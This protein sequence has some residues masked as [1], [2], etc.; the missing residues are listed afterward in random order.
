MLRG[1][2]LRVR[3]VRSPVSI[4]N[5][6]KFRAWDDRSA[7]MR[8]GAGNRQGLWSGGHGCCGWAQYNAAIYRARSRL[9][10]RALQTLAAARHKR[11]QRRLNICAIARSSHS[12]LGRNAFGAIPVRLYQIGPAAPTVGVHLYDSGTAYVRD[13]S[14][15]KCDQSR[16]PPYALAPHST[17][18]AIQ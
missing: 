11:R 9:T 8:V 6:N 5:L 14:T 7:R 13:P 4:C 1:G 3:N 10:A 2:T 16:Y 12:L 18:S 15:L 17:V